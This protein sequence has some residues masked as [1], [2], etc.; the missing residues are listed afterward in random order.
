MT[1][2]HVVVIGGGF[3]GVAAAVTLRNRGARVT[4]IE[5]RP[6]LGGRARSDV[7]DDLSID[8]G[9]QLITSGYTRTVQLVGAHLERDA[10]HDIVVRN[11]ERLPL[12]FGSLRSLLSFSGL[13]ALEKVRLAT[14]LLPLLARYHDALDAFGAR[15]PESLDTESVR[16]FVERRIGAAA[17]DTLAE[18]PC[19]GFYNVAASDVS[20]AFYLSLGRYGSEGDTMAPKRGWSDALGAVLTGVDRIMDARVV[21]IDI[22]Q[23]ANGRASR[24]SVRE[25]TGR[26]WDANAA[27]IATDPRTAH[28]FLAPHLGTDHAL[29]QWLG[30]VPLRATLTLALALDT[31]PPHDAFGVFQDV[32]VARTVS[33]C[34][35]HGA[36]HTSARA[37]R[38]VVLAWPTPRALDAMGDMSAE[39][40]TARM[41]PDVEALVPEV[42]GHVTRA[43]VYR[44][45][46]GSP[47]PFIGFVRDRVRA[48]ALA[49]AI[50]LPLALAGD[51]LTT[52][53]IEGAVASGEDAAARIAARV[54]LA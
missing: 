41:L 31:A 45:H 2:T 19:N 7:L 18:P 27:V 47:V 12:R 42:R 23:D 34:A 20:L 28:D 11:G 50:D 51:Y 43:R 9:A 38:D 48:T 16:A 8:T 1:D 33:A 37:E 29:S 4:L 54:G 53:L 13:S 36:K 25:A 3:A 22:A 24:V 5:A 39:S 40:I 26:A 32:R 6:T 17:A 10:A 35:V 46:H 30:A 44:F 14:Y 49:H 52:P 21:A 15:L